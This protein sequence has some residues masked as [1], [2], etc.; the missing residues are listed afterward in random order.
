MT[1]T[2][3]VVFVIAGCACAVS[4]IAP[5][6]LQ[7]PD[8]MWR[9]VSARDFLV[10]TL[11]DRPIVGFVFNPDSGHVSGYSGC[12]RFHGTYVYRGDSLSFGPLVLTKMFCQSGSDI[13]RAVV[14]ALRDVVTVRL[15]SGALIGKGAASDTVIIAR[16]ESHKRP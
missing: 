14:E 6:P 15:E 12:N 4:C 1:M 13:E 16:R 5:E 7:T 9:V 2:W 11:A 3:F 8:T 10:P